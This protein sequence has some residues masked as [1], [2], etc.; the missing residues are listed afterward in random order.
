MNALKNMEFI[1][2]VAAIVAVTAATKAPVK[3]VAPSAAPAIVTSNTEMIKVV[4]AAKRPSK[5]E[6]AQLA[7]L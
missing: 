7:V 6:K 1:F 4:V 5:E 2:V 3:P